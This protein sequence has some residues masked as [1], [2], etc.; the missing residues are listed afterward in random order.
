MYKGDT[1]YKCSEERIKETLSGLKKHK[2]SRKYIISRLEALGGKSETDDLGN[3]YVTLPGSSPDSK[4][5][6]SKKIVLSCPDS[7]DSAG[8]CSAVEI[9]GT[10]TAEEIQ[11]THA[12]TVLLWND[13]PSEDEWEL[14]PAMGTLCLEYLP[15]EIRSDYKDIKPK[16]SA[17]GSKQNRLNTRDFRFMF[18]MHTAAVPDGIAVA[19]IV[20]ASVGRPKFRFNEK[21]TKLTED[22]AALC[23]INTEKLHYSPDRDTW[24]AANMLPTAVILVSSDDTR[25]YAD[26]ATVLLNAVLQADK[27]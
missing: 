15:E 7:S 12:L 16:K 17:K 20:T 9:I 25:K 27:S 1:L 13:E 4:K 21:L 3:V 26:A 14:V 19:D 10:L 18:E 24:I 6:D 11:L 23:G 8:V 5:P 22:S 2:D